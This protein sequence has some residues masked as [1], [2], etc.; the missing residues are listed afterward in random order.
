MEKKTIEMQNTQSPG[1]IMMR[2]H[3][4]S[5]VLCLFLILVPLLISV[6]FKDTEIDSPQMILF[7]RHCFVENEFWISPENDFTKHSLALLE[8]GGRLFI[9]GIICMIA[10][11]LMLRLTH[12]TKQK[13]LYP[14]AASYSV[15]SML[16]VL[17][18]L[19]DYLLNGGLPLQYNR[20]M[21]W[22]RS[23]RSLHGVLPILVCSGVITTFLYYVVNDR[24]IVKN[25]KVSD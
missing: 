20:L 5:Y 16:V 4:P 21:L 19:G 1:E 13:H 7:L 14:F 3:V 2:K 10:E 17:S 18:I 6:L 25:Q 8:D 23:V 22:G 15:Y 9:Q 11:I 24:L 12:R